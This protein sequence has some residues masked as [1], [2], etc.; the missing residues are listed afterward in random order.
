MGRWMAALTR[1]LSGRGHPDHSLF[2]TE[3]ERPDIGQDGF[4]STLFLVAVTDSPYLPE[5]AENNTIQV[6]SISLYINDIL[7]TLRPAQLQDTL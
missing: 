7:L 5:D 3:P 1:Y 2:A 4:R 6:N